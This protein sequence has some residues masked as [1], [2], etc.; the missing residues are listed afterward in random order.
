MKLHMRKIRIMTERSVMLM[1]AML[2][3]A[4]R[5]GTGASMSSVYGVDFPLQEKQGLRR[6]IQMHGLLLSIPNW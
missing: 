5:E 2:Q 4:I 6:I 1:S 3:K